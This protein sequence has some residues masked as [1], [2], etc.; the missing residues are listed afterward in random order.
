MANDVPCCEGSADLECDVVKESIH[1]MD[2]I[3]NC[4][5]HVIEADRS[6]KKIKKHKCIIFC[7]R[8]FIMEGNLANHVR[9]D[10]KSMKKKPCPTCGKK[11][12]TAELVRTHK[13]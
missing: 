12:K 13:C 7:A 5:K 6:G 3:D 2:Q 8:P 11:L 1:V 10:H 4:N 9:Q